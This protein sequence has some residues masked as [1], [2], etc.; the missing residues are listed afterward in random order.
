VTL[1]Q[2]VLVAGHRP[3]TLFELLLLA[4]GLGLLLLVFA[5]IMVWRLA[6][7][8]KAEA[9][10]QY[11]RTAELEYR[12]AELSGSLHGFAQQS[13]GLQMQMQNTLDERLDQVSHRVGVGLHEQTKAT[14]QSLGALQERMAVIDAAQANLTALSGEMLSLKDIL[15]NKQTRGVFGQGRMEAIIKDGL[16]AKAFA[17]QATLSNGTR[18]DCVI[19]LPDSELRLVIDAK[20]PL[21]A[22]NAMRHATDEAERRAAEQRLKG[23][24]LKHVKDIA[25]KYLIS[26]ETHE[27]AIMFVPSESVYAELNENFDDVVQKAHRLRVILASPNVLMLLV[28]TMQ[29]IVKDSMM[30]EQ[31]H[32]IKGEVVKLLDD[33]NR[34]RERTGSL[35]RHFEQAGADIE[36]IQVSTEQISRR[37]LRIESLELEEPAKVADASAARPKLVGSG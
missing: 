13:Q 26:G 9:L 11:R 27:T 8:R 21:E 14:V 31:A 18:P 35:K 23:D 30:R 7:A 28:Q 16:H 22:Y 29:A 6:R 3:I 20:F 32:V 24:V 33:V 1:D 37:G 19:T 34:L 5:T 15:S 12:L 25:E 17:F 10:E 2:I 36:K 4:A